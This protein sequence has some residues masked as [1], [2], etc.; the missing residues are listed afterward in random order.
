MIVILS[1]PIEHTLLLTFLLV[2]Q[3]GTKLVSKC[4]I[5]K[6]RD[7][8]NSLSQRLYWLNP[9]P[10]N[11]R[12]VNSIYSQT[13]MPPIFGANKHEQNA[14]AQRGVIGSSTD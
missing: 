2:P 9:F 3:I 6:I 1:A 7:C 5:Q 12:F 13:D 14:I 4:E 11:T 8:N 10:M